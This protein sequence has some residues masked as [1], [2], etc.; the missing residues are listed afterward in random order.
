[1][2][3]VRSTGTRVGQEAFDA[4]PASVKLRPL[5]DQ[6][7]LDP[8][9]WPFSQIIHVVYGGRTLRGKV[10]AIGPGVYPI[11]YNDRKGKRTKSWSS[12]QF[13]PCDVHVGDVVQIGGIEIGGYLNPTFR[14]GDRE[15]VVCREEDVTVI[16]ET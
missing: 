2:S 13:R 4:L 5:R 15:V 8:M 3:A 16:E 11:R 10:L 9:P 12:L 14:Y 1:M 7:I 6:I